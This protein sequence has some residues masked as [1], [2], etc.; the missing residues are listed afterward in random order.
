VVVA[1]TQMV[2]ILEFNSQPTLSVILCQQKSPKPARYHTRRMT[3]GCSD[4]LNLQHK[5]LSSS[6][7][8][9]F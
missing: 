7:P 6:T 8:H 1:R 3:R 9:R 4:L 5:E 2:V